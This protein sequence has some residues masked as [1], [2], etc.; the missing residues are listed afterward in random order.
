MI[1]A[2]ALSQ[3]RTFVAIGHLDGR[4]HLFDL[5]D[6]SKPART[7]QTS[8]RALVASG[9][10]EGHL[11]GSRIVHVGFV[12]ARHTAIVS[13]DEYGLAFYHSLGKVLFVEA[14]DELRLLGKYPIEVNPQDPAK[15]GSRRP[16]PKENKTPP[17]WL[18]QSPNI[19]SMLPLPLGTNPHQTDTYNVVALITM[20][21]LVVV[22]I[23]PSPKTWYRKRRIEDRFAAIDVDSASAPA[24]CLAWFPSVQIKAD[25]ATGEAAST[26]TPTLAYSWNSTVQL[27][28]VREHLPE[29][30]A[31]SAKRG[32]PHEQGKLIFEEI[33]SWHS[34]GPIRRLQWLSPYVSVIISP[35][36][37]K[38]ESVPANPLSAG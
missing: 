19:I 30:L 6:P 37:Q 22:A 34:S 12:G 28:T 1:T 13:S 33:G 38:T 24:A 16:S 18:R 4:L 21:K 15:S 8:T 2:I 27:V 10:R 29:S 31:K 9:R 3:D 14:T 23:K 35:F 32:V 5:A 26:T 36:P 20:V 11:H 17:R 7:V 25:E